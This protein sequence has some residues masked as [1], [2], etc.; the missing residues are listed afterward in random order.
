MQERCT[1]QQQWVWSAECNA[2]KTVTTVNLLEQSP[3]Q[4]AW[5][6]CCFASSDS[7]AAPTCPGFCLP[8]MPAV[9]LTAADK[10]AGMLTTFCWTSALHEAA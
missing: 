8:W 1:E 2:R 5:Q 3:R 6:R 10:P 7:A 9:A 4:L